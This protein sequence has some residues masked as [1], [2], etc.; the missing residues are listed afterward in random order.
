MVDE[1]VQTH[2][3]GS[4]ERLSVLLI[5]MNCIRRR[6]RIPTAPVRLIQNFL[7]PIPVLITGCRD[8][9]L[10]MLRQIDG[11]LA[12]D[13]IYVCCGGVWCMAYHR[14]TD[15]LFVGCYDDSIRLYSLCPFQIRSTMFLNS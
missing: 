15:G 8:G 13:P 7:M 5:Q 3:A 12:E 9:R 14:E 6:V 10:C 1:V 2:W 11:T 4:A